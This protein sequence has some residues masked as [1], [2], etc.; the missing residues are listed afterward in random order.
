MNIYTV[1][2]GDSLYSISQQYNV[3]YT[4]LA[5]DNEIDASVPLIVGESL[6]IDT[7]STK[8][9]DIEVNGFINP[10]IKLDVLNKTLPYLT[11]LSIFSYSA[12]VTGTLETIED[13]T[14][15][16]LAKAQ[17]VAPMMVVNNRDFSSSVAHQI[18]NNYELQ[19]TLLNNIVYVLESKGYYGINFDLEYIYEYDRYTYNRFLNRAVTLLRSMGYKVFTSLAPKYNESQQG[20]LYT[21]HDYRYHGNSVDRVVLMTYEWGHTYSSPRAVAPV[22]QVSRVLDYATTAIPPSKILMGVPNYGYDWTL[23]W[24]ND[25][26]ARAIGNTN[27]VNTARNVKASIEFDQESQTPHYSY[28]DKNKKQHVVW[29]EDARSIYQKL[30][31]VNKYN[32]AGVSYWTINRFF[33]QNWVILDSMYNIVKVNI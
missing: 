26:P 1:K 30:L 13:E 29:F 8:L 20:L 3:Q 27:A 11:Y 23:P 9:G 25:V 12:N 18:F 19:T 14:F 31:L 15:I 5:S 24:V 2:T 16:R 4:K 17:G 28:Y 32:I 22:D 7:P 21:A 6:V 33:K 10:N